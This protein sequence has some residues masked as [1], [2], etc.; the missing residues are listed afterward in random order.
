MTGMGTHSR[1]KLAGRFTMTSTGNTALCTLRDP[2][3]RTPICTQ[4]TDLALHVRTGLQLKGSCS[5]ALT[6]FIYFLDDT[7]VDTT[8]LR[9]LCQPPHC[10]CERPCC[11]QG[12]LTK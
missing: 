6:N 9:G 10:L 4:L 5:G 2:S 11:G 1:E 7:A 3:D 12:W 8:V